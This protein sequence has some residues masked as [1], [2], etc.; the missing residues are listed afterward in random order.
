MS[1]SI[2]FSLSLTPETFDLIILGGGAAGFFTAA[3]C[4]PHLKTLI[5]EKN[6]E[7]LQ[8]V[9]VSGG[10]RCNV[11][12]AC[13]DSDKLIEN[14]P[15]GKEFLREPFSRFGPEE[16][17]HWLA[18]KGVKT[19]T[20]ADGRMF[21][22][23][24]NSQ[25]VINCF[26]TET[27]R[28][29]TQLKTNARVV[30][31][32]P[33]DGKWQV[34]LVSGESLLC[35]WLVI[36]AGSDKHIWNCLQNLGLRVIDPVPSLFTFNIA[37]SDLHKLAGVSFGKIIVKTRNQEM[38]GPAL[39]THWGLSGPAILKLSA[40]G[41]VDF[42]QL[43]YKFKIQV[44][45]LPDI[46][47]TEIQEELR[48]L[49]QNESRKKVVNTIPFDLSK[50]FWEYICSKA[51]IREFQNWSETGKRHFESLTT[52][53]K[54]TPF[55]VH[56]KSTFKE[57]FVTA[58]GIALEEL[59]QETFQLKKHPGLFAAGEVLNIDAV[60]GGFNFQAAWTGGWHISQALNKS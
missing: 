40:W 8:K 34:D 3:N 52:L 15:R 32:S 31:F 57:E 33:V 60:T 13:F 41:A 29:G 49:Q 2:L 59:D 6:R 9:K 14:Y 18:K 5:L 26:L 19:K 16:M 1:N 12:H 27:K 47:K 7:P 42:S 39:I 46:T 28:R 58:G 17:I 20:E 50:R 44:N 56:G 24:D 45:F 43:D 22:A 11:T 30:N 54:E 38:S 37:D 48:K 10:G 36:T 55:E 35:K 25:T 21:P 4:P 51:G 23:S 53:L